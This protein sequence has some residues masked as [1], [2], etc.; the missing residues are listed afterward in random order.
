M[1][2]G[3]RLVLE[4]WLIELSLMEGKCGCRRVNRSPRSQADFKAHAAKYIS[5]YYILY[6]CEILI[7]FG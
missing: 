7:F 5:L 3:G 4:K 2:T 6:E 1:R